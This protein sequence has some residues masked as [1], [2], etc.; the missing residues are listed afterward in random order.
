MVQ[1]VGVAVSIGGTGMLAA[2]TR[3]LA[4]EHET[5]LVV[6]RHAAQFCASLPNTLPLDANW[7]ASDFSEQV[8]T[9][10]DRLPPPRTALL[11]LHRMETD[12]PTL[13]PR[14]GQARIVLVLGS[15]DG[16]PRLP[17]FF[18]VVTI[19]LGSMPTATGRRWLTNDEISAGAIAA[20]EDG[21][22]RIVGELR[23][24]R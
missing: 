14:F 21:R 9:A 13:L 11:W 19:R 22:S 8:S 15:M 4:A 2:A 17:P 18:T 12:F 20:L 7:N 1:R 6:A 5:T 10:L 23:P 24:L 3:H 16:Q